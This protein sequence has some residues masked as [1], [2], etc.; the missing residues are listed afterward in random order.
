MTLDGYRHREPGAKMSIL[1]YGTSPELCQIQLKSLPA[2]LSSIFNSIVFF[3]LFQCCGVN[4]PNDWQQNIYFACDSMA[5]Q[6]CSVPFSCCI[7][8]SVHCPARFSVAQYFISSLPV[9]RKRGM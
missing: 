6:R 8:V 1:S 7:I 5:F 3:Q 9:C 4:S 2:H